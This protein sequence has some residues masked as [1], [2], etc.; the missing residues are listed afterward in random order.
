[1][2]VYLLRAMSGGTS[3][4]RV[5]VA[6]QLLL[7]ALI[8]IGIWAA[9]PARW[10]PVDVIGTGLAVL[11]GLGALGLL[12]G[13]AWGRLVS[14]VASWSTLVIGATAVTLLAFVV[15]HLS[16]LYGPVGAGGA[17]LMGTMAALVLPYLVG[18]P[19]LQLRWLPARDA[20]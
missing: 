16:G 19:L 12:S 4:V 20:T 15:S 2:G 7:A 3:R 9:L 13:K 5:L 6:S 17:L 1:M 14:L 8:V 11:H 18:L 10:W